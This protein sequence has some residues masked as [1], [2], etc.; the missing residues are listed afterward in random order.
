MALAPS[1]DFVSVPSSA[2]HQSIE[3]ALIQIAAGY[4][5]R[6]LAVDVANCLEH[7]FAAVSLRVGVAE[8]QRFPRTGRSARRHRCTAEGAALERDVDFHGRITA[9]IEDLA[10]VQ[11]GI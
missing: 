8:F 9:G 11:T 10:P 2:Q 7:T 5:A 6:D 4:C 3:R 1:R